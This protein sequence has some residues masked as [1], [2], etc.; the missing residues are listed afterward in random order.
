MNRLAATTRGVA[1]LLAVALLATSGWGWYLGRVAD[2]SVSRTNAIP[3]SGNEGTGRAGE[4][5]NLLLV[6][7]DSRASA[8][9]EQLD[10]LNTEASKGINTDTMILAH[11]PADGSGAS[12]VS[13]PRDSYVQIPGYGWDKLNAAYA[14]GYT[15]EAPDD[16]TDKQKQAAG[17]QLLIRTISQLTGLQID[18][19]AE[20]DLLGFFNLSSVV[21]GVEVNL[22]EPAQDSFSGVDL[23]AGVQTISGEQAL[24]FVRQRHGL[25][26]GDFD[27]IVRQQTFIGGM[28]RKMLSDNVLLDLGKQRE[29]VGA[30][31]D[32]LT[33]DQSLDLFELAGQMQSATAGNVEFQTVPNVGTDQEDGK[34]IVRLEDEDTLHDFF[35]QLSAAPEE[36]D[37]PSSEAPAT[38]D[39]STVEVDVYNGS[40]ISGLAGKA[41][42]ALTAGGFAVGATGNASSMDHEQTEVRHAAGDEALAQTVAAAIPGAVVKESDDA[43]TGTVQLVLGSDFNG[44]GQAVTPAPA[45][46]AT[47]T[48]DPRTAA[49]TTCIN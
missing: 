4:A 42:D 6:G 29:L 8:T 32:S 25:P 35:A 3:T 46:T 20:V 2:A 18:H 23:D 21:G 17:A 10:A 31:A 14:Y 34:S 48:E 43:A 41:A 15:R 30:A 9:E 47:E 36:E 38:V 1:A 24:A 11:V 27:R 5:L 44:V 40:G 37:A 22:C 49:D 26:R 7:N 16:A 19:Y 45:A 39:P 12:F 28:I 13:F 33:V